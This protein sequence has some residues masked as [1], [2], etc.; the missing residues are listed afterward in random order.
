MTSF[1]VTLNFHSILKLSVSE[2]TSSLISLPV[3]TIGM[4]ATY[5]ESLPAQV[6]LTTFGWNH[7][8]PYI[9]RQTGRTK[10]QAG[11]NRG[12]EHHPWYNPGGWKAHSAKALPFNSTQRSYVFLDLETCYEE[13]F[14]NYGWGLTANSDRENGRPYLSSSGGQI[15][16][17]KA[18]CPV[19]D[20]ILDS[21]MFQDP[22]TNHSSVLVL[23]DCG[24]N[25]PPQW[26]CLNRKHNSKL[27]QRHVS[28]VSESQSFSN[29]RSALDLGLPPPA[30]H[31]VPWSPSQEAAIANLE[32]NTRPYLFTFTGNF[33][34]PARQ[35]LLKLH[36][37]LAGIL[38]QPHFGGSMNTSFIGRGVHEQFANLKGAYT[39]LMGQSRF[40]GVP[41]GDN[42]FSYRFTEALSG[43][44]IP[45]VYADGWVLPFSESLIDWKDIAIIVP[46]RD[47][48]RTLEYLN[49][50]TLE[51]E[52]EMRKR[53]YDFYKR[54]MA[55]PEGVIAGIVESLELLLQDSTLK[56]KRINYR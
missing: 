28:I 18:V 34:H 15:R 36:D 10:F 32:E 54:Y 45:V 3:S 52:L 20:Q 6:L 33:R 4:A 12:I 46:E 29:Y 13:N 21:P 51:K 48:A 2:P 1:I 41:R 19:I 43:G 26:S 39:T 37:P 11:L 49:N 44:C 27:N 9:A 14:P 16:H 8:D 25:G 24:W 42:L 22:R 17:M 50:T 31:T 38:V 23:F 40:A 55:T 35:E 47:A 5:L 30:I 7:P 53:G 56:D